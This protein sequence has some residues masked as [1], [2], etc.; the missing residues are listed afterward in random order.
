MPNASALRSRS[1][2][3]AYTEGNEDQS[4]R[5]ALV[6]LAISY[7]A[8]RRSINLGTMRNDHRSVLTKGASSTGSDADSVLLFFS[9]HSKIRALNCEQPDQG[10]ARESSST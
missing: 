6:V 5:A 7:R 4:A 10:T 2:V 9:N 3:R 1:L 8:A